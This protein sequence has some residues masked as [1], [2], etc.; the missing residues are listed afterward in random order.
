MSFDRIVIVGTTGSGKST[1]AQELA[2]IT[3]AEHVELDAI[4]HQPDWGHLPVEE[5]HRRLTE[6]AARPRWIVDGNYVDLTEHILW[7]R[8]ELIVWLDM[9]LRLVLARLVRRSI[10][11]IVRRTEL[12]H[13]NRETW[14]MLFSQESI[15]LWAVKSHGR[16]RRQLPVKLA[17][18]MLPAEYAVRLTHPREVKAWLA[19]LRCRIETFPA[20]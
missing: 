11:R 5:F 6:L 18:P 12:W 9:P 17:P 13:G 10:T 20:A 1:L 16:H 4:N 15:V 7:P 8:A 2:H 14:A 19:S 3:G